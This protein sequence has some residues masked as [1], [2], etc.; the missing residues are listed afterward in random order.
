MKWSTTLKT[1][2]IRIK[3]GKATGQATPSKGIKS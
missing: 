2:D 3:Q 1:L